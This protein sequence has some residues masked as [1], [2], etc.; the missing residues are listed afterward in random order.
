MITEPNEQH[1]GELNPQSEVRSQEWLETEISR[2]D[3]MNLVAEMAASVSHEVR[4]PMTTVRGFLQMLRNKEDLS[5]YAPHFDL[6]IEEL[7]RANSMITE[8]LSVAR[9][10]PA[11]HKPGDLASIVGVLMPLLDANALMTG[12]LLTYEGDSVPLAMLDDKDIR[13]L[14]LNLVKNALEAMQPGGRVTIR[15][16]QEDSEVVLS[17]S[18]Q[19]SGIPTAV[20]AKLGT[21]FTTTK[22][23]GTGLGLAVCYQIAN[24]HHAKLSYETGPDG[25]TFYV[26]FPV[27]KSAAED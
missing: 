12:N 11:E 17:V 20:Q 24:R 13:Q 16:Y 3:K 19:G 10:K 25:T 27:L 18:D 15:T 21:P 5:A 14:I 4:N 23:K 2:L 6:M 22:E 1:T 26:R 7:D 8:F 9:N